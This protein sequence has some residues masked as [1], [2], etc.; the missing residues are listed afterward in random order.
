VRNGLDGCVDQILIPF[1]F[2]HGHRQTFR[3][4]HPASE[5]L[6]TIGSKGIAWI[7]TNEP[8]FAIAGRRQATVPANSASIL[9][10]LL[11]RM[12]YAGVPRARLHMVYVHEA[13]R[14]CSRAPRSPAYQGHEWKR[15]G[16]WSTSRVFES[17]WHSWLS[18]LDGAGRRILHRRPVL[19]LPGRHREPLERRGNSKPSWARCATYASADNSPRR[20]NA[21]G[22]HLFC[23]SPLWFGGSAR[24]WGR[25]ASALRFE[26]VLASG[27]PIPEVLRHR[28]IEECQFGGVA[29]GVRGGRHG[30]ILGSGSREL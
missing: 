21:G 25:S 14:P 18:H 24:A 1:S 6:R 22:S 4:R 3:P 26:G 7:E 17:R 13:T 8:A 23:G 15:S 20:S 19:M 12:A 27:H 28:D 5:L 9:Q 30:S 11:F 16:G 2:I 10:R 29:A